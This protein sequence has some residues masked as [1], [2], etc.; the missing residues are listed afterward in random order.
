MS[1]ILLL[2]L[3]YLFLA[4]KSAIPRVVRGEDGRAQLA[5]APG[6][7]A[8]APA[9]SVAEL[10]AAEEEAAEIL[11]QEPP[12]AAEPASSSAEPASSAAEPVEEKASSTRWTAPKAKRRPADLPA[13]V[14]VGW[15]PEGDK[16]AEKAAAATE[17]EILL[18]R[19]ASGDADALARER[20]AAAGLAAYLFGGGVRISVV[21]EYQRKMGGARPSGTLDAPT[22][23]RMKALGVRPPAIAGRKRPS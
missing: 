17:E 10:E 1:P 7:Q 12:S 21:R 6:P 20:A 5:F 14:P 18:D 13:A 16:A 11:A 9:P 8:W 3:A 4:R 22:V 15:T 19:I 23:A 2:G